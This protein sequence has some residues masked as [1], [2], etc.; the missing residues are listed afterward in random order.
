MCKKLSAVFLSL[1]LASH[2][3]SADERRTRL[4]YDD[5]TPELGKPEIGLEVGFYEYGDEEERFTLGEANV[6][7]VALV[8]RHQLLKK[9]TLSA[10]I[11]YIYFEPDQGDS[12]SDIGDVEVGAELEAYKG[13]LCYP[14]VIPHVNVD[15][16]TADLASPEGLGDET[17]SLGVS[18]GTVTHDVITWVGDASY[19]INGNAENSL[20]LS[21]SLLWDID[22]DFAVGVEGQIRENGQSQ[23]VELLDTVG[24]SD[25]SAGMIMGSMH[26]NA[27]EH[28]AYS[29]YFGGGLE[30]TLDAFA[31]LKTTYSF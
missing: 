1:L 28:L 23:G 6:T 29:I 4:T 2:F 13:V 21:A 10:R 30:R 24:R 25:G 19:E 26:Y 17:V 20:V 7:E 14:W 15:F 5:R 18:V 22:K 16:G 27:T 9:F 11:P 8:L 3:V 12:E 31:L